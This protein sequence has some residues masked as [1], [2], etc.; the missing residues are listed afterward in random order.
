[1]GACL[2]TTAQVKATIKT[3][4]EAGLTVDHDKEAGTVRIFD[5]DQECYWAIQKGS[6][7]PW[8]CRTVVTANVSWG[9]A[10]S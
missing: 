10:V 1:M 7:G 2:G 5:G 4:R 6:G 3:A 9:Q 8:I